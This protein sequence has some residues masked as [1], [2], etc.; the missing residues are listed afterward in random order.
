[1]SESI[2]QYLHQLGRI[3]HLLLGDNLVGTYLHGSAVLGG[4]NPA[5]SDLDVLVVVDDPVAADTRRA[6]VERVSESTLPCPAAGLELSVVRLSAAQHPAPSTAYELHIN[7]HDN[8]VVEDNGRGDPDL[9]LHFL[10]C[11]QHGRLLGAGR[12]AS[13]VFAP[14]PTPMVLDQF[15]NELEWAMKD[16]DVPSRYLV[17]NAARNWYFI[18]TGHVI[19]KIAGGG[20]AR[21]HIPDPAVID[22]ALEDQE[23]DT[24]G[25]AQRTDPAEARRFAAEVLEKIKAAIAHHRPGTA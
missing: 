15:R 8:K 21:A 5:R 14:L 16:P 22:A 4:F 11:R 20:W 23:D 6:F 24:S 18:E 13:S 1:M 9:I 3:I 12:R 25:Q 17:L 7:T 2:E 19:S 10:I